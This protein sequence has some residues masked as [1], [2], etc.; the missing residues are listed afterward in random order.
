MYRD[1]VT[2]K[3]KT[4]DFDAALA[5]LE[6]LVEKLEHGDLPLEESLRHFERGVA[7]TRQCQLALKSAQQRVALLTRR[8]GDETLAPF[9]AEPEYAAQGD[10]DAG[11]LDR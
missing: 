5:E 9:D 1:R 4:P 3:Q 2:R 8:D 10:A 7:L 11:D 6:A